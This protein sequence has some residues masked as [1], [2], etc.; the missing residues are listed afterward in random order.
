M[1]EIISYLVIFLG[2]SMLILVYVA[3]K[4]PKDPK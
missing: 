4:D 3:G 1:I 2:I